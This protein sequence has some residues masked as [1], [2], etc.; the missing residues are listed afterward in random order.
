MINI[1][2]AFLIGCIWG[3]FTAVIMEFFQEQENALV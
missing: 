2:Y 3:Y 1:I